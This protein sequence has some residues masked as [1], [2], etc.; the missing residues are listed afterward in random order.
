MGSQ[1]PEHLLSESWTDALQS[2]DP[3]GQKAG[4]VIVAFIQGQPGE[5]VGVDSVR[6]LQPFT[7]NRCLAITGWT[8]YQNQ[9]NVRLQTAIQ[10][11]HQSLTMDNLRASERE[12]EFG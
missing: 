1:H 5:L 12:A 2:R 6:C 4:D 9:G 11:L 10:Y 3:V 7:D 8:A